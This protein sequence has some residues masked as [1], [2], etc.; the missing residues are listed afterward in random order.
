MTDTIGEPRRT[1]LISLLAGTAAAGMAAT[2]RGAVVAPT[3]PEFVGLEGWLNAEA[4]LTLA[5]LRG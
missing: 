4:P 3:A 5:G 1:L 2:G